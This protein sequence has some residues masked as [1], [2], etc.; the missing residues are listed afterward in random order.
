[1]ESR[2]T[3]LLASFPA[4]SPAARRCIFP[5]PK[6]GRVPEATWTGSA[7]PH[8]HAPPRSQAPFRPHSFLCLRPFRKQPVQNPAPPSDMY[9]RA[10]PIG[11]WARR[12]TTYFPSVFPRTSKAPPPHEARRANT[13]HLRR[14]ILVRPGFASCGPRGDGQSSRPGNLGLLNGFWVPQHSCCCAGGP[15]R[16]LPAGAEHLRGPANT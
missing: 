16:S 12:P 13:P 2:A 14:H 8:P 9:Y 5:R 11:R 15:R 6:S 3:A 7:R 10:E 1:M 4:D